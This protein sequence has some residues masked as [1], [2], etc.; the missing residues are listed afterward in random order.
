MTSR[1]FPA[2]CCALTIGLTTTTL[3]ACSDTDSETAQTQ[4]QQPAT[5]EGVLDSYTAT[6]GLLAGDMPAAHDANDEEMHEI[7]RIYLEALGKSRAAQDGA[8]QDNADQ[9]GA[10]QDSAEQNNAG[11]DDIAQELTGQI[12]PFISDDDAKALDKYIE[13]SGLDRLVAFDEGNETGI[14]DMF[15]YGFITSLL[16]SESAT[17]AE[18]A[19]AQVSQISPDTI[20]LDG[21][22]RAVIPATTGEGSSAVFVAGEDVEFVRE[23]GSWRVVIDNATLSGVAAPTV[24]LIGMMAA[25]SGADVSNSADPNAIADSLVKSVRELQQKAEA[26]N[27]GTEGVNTDAR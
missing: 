18:Q 7:L 10:D 4:T 11:Q 13:K 26:E 3:A 19:R 8:K 23:D 2:L 9:D 24:M 14:Y 20:Q 6:V 1:I 17:M 12:G 15:Y 5:P 27:A 21:E 16:G 22:D 25:E